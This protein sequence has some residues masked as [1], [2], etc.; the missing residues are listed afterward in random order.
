MTPLIR[1]FSALAKHEGLAK[2]A[3]WFDMGHL[4]DYPG[5]R[6]ELETTPLPFNS[7]AYVVKSK[8]DKKILI[9]AT[10]D[11]NEIRT[12]GISV[13]KNRVKVS[14]TVSLYIDSNGVYMEEGCSENERKVG[15]IAFSMLSN[16]LS[17]INPVGCKYLPKENSLINKKQ[18]KNGKKPSEYEWRTVKIKPPVER[19]EQKGGTHSSPRLHERRGHWRLCPSGK[20]VWVKSCLVGD[21]DKGVI[22]KDYKVEALKTEAFIKR[23]LE[24]D[25]K[26]APTLKAHP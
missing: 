24:L 22:E 10:Q 13:S 18:M 9:V 3:V 16:F 14:R 4:E 21:P 17:R 7:C 5:I 20:Q 26:D 25:T 15:L 8:D 12:T 23:Q 1:E 6:R 19:A 11:G 2:G